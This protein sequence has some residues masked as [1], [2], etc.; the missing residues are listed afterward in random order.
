M[1]FLYCIAVWS[2]FKFILWLAIWSNHEVPISIRTTTLLSCCLIV[3]GTKA[4]SISYV[5]L[6]PTTLSLLW[7]L[8]TD[9]GPR[10]TELCLTRAGS[11]TFQDGRTAHPHHLTRSSYVANSTPFTPPPTAHLSSS[12]APATNANGSNALFLTHLQLR[13][14]YFFLPP[15]RVRRLTIFLLSERLNLCSG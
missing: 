11:F 14:S 8:A 1:F 9:S 12:T 4:I 3:L 6:L 15:I 7:M 5:N 13:L 10:E 2:N